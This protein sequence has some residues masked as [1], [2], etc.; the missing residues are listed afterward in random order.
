MQEQILKDY[1]E[2]IAKYAEGLDK[3]RILN[4]YRKVAVFLGNENKKFQI[5]KI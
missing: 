4:A 2:D 5:T 1:Q 3:S